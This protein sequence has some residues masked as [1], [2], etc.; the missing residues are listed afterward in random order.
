MFAGL[1]GVGGDTDDRGRIHTG[2]LL[3]KE[4]MLAGS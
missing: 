2:S 1:I 4:M 3:I